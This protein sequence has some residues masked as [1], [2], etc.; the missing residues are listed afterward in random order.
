ME[1][2][3]GLSEDSTEP[4]KILHEKGFSLIAGIDEAG[5]GPLAGPVVA[6]AVIFAQTWTHPE[7]K[8]SKQLT[9]QKRE[10]LYHIVSQEALA[11]GC[12]LVEPAEIDQINILQASLKAMRMAVESLALEPDFLLIDGLHPID[13]SVPQISIKKGDQKS[14][15]IAAA[16]IMAKVTRDAIM[17]QYHELYPQY[18]FVQNKGYGTQEHLRA[19]VEY[20]QC[21]IH[22]KTFKTVMDGRIINK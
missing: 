3:F 7:I 5:R 13:I 21:P 15:S 8:D 4:E 20:G 1:L 18:N 14:L 17:K 9:S 2:L 22:R 12:A 6:A 10:V 16:S 11:W 19:L